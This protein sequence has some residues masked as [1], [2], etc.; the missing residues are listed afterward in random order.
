MKFTRVQVSG[1]AVQVSRHDHKFGST[2]RT[3]GCGGTDTGARQRAANG[4]N[5]G[6]ARHGTSGSKDTHGQGVPGAA[7]LGWDNKW[8]NHAG[9][10]CLGWVGE[11]ERP[12]G[13]ELYTPDLRS[14]LD[15]FSEREREREVQPR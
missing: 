5:G 12:Y 14:L 4:P 3:D 1:I 9:V 8:V 10:R 11:F 7:A 13:L 2:G 15:F 6:P